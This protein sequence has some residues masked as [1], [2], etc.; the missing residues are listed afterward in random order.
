VSLLKPL[1]QG[2]GYLK[3][4][5]LGFQKSGK[6]FTATQLAIGTRD[7]MGAKGPIAMFDTEGGSEYIA[8]M[9]R[10]A[11]GLDLLGVRSRSFD[12]LL[13]MAREA[14]KAGVSAL[15]V[16]SVTHV[17]RELCDAYLQQVNDRKRQWAQRK[18]WN[19]K[20]QTNLEFQDWNPIKAKWAEWTEWYLNSPVH[21]IICGRAGWEYDEEKDEE[22]GKKKLVKVGTKMKT[23]AEFGFEPS[24]LIEMERENERRQDGTVVQVHRATV[25]GDRF[26][27]VNGR[28]FDN[29]TFKDFQ[30]HLEKLKPGVHAPIDTTVK[31]DM[32]VDEGGAD[33]WQQEKRA[34]TI[35]A[36]ELQG[37]L[38]ARWP[39]QTA[40]EKKAKADALQK[41]LGT[42]SWTAVESMRADEISAGLSR[43]RD[44]FAAEGDDLPPEMR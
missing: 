33:P 37:E 15:L 21:V 28:T 4:G 10:D 18:G 20:P 30:P 2:Q 26:N 1:G 22:T 23:E 42:R 8:A 27:V 17:W 12:D 14:E 9:V 5:F 35:L 43:L 41:F 32:H 36:E 31:S 6:T 25:I 44:S 38:T 3:A 39:G 40:V 16:D 13:N 29:P 11:T 19:F 34:R 24:L 7:F